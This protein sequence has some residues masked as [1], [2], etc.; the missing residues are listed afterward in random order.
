[1]IERITENWLTKASEREFGTAFCQ[2]LLSRGFRVLHLTRHGPTEHGKDVIALDPK[3]LPTGFQLKAGDIDQNRWRR[4]YGEIEDLIRL[5]PNHPSIAGNQ[6]HRAFLV[7]TGQLKEEVR[8]AIS[9]YNRGIP[10]G[11][12]RLETWVGGELL[13]DCVD[14][15]GQ[16]LPRDVPNFGRFLDLLRMDGRDLPDLKLVSEFLTEVLPLEDSSL[17]DRGVTRAIGSGALLVSYISH[18]HEDRENHVGLVQIWVAY[19]AHV[20]ASAQRYNLPDNE[21]LPS[22]MLAWNAIG[23]A[24]DILAE[25]LAGRS[26]LVQGNAFVD[27]LAY[28]SR[29]TL[30][31]GVLAAYALSQF[32]MGED[33]WANS[34]LDRIL[35][36]RVSEMQ[37]W[38]EGSVP[39][40]LAFAW[41]IELCGDSGRAVALV[42]GCA[43]SLTKAAQVG[44]HPNPYYGL[45]QCLRYNLGLDHPQ[46]GF[47]GYSYTLCSLMH[48]LARRLCRDR[49]ATMWRDASHVRLAEFIPRPLWRTGLWRSPM[50][51]T[52]YGFLDTPQSWKELLARAQA[53]PKSRLPHAFRLVQWFLPLFLVVYPHR[54]RPAAVWEIDTALGLRKHLA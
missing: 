50:G 5:R 27:S 37:F 15:H 12:P 7:A 31:T 30:L 11:Y 28:G 22:F 36:P 33:N 46:E 41:Y 49:L 6:R 2:L 34:S 21:W 9:D 8:L 16:F 18:A 1:M 42:D 4:M 14:L 26:H 32:L 35:A 23:R 38:G 13:K 17:R 29:I 48:W 39:C 47:R 44:G 51:N 25:E 54:M 10:R 43:R 3:G 19:A 53:I 20:L 24:C 45:E 52:C 40:L